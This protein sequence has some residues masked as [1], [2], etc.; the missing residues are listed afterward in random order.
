[1]KILIL[2][3]SSIGDIVLTTPVIRCL[4]N[5]INDLEI[6]YL[7]KSKFKIIL[8]NN[9]YIDKMYDFEK[10]VAEII[11]NL[12]AENYDY[13]I[14]LHNNLRSLSLKIK[15]KRKSSTFPKLNIKKWLLVN[16][17][18]NKMP[19]KHIVERYFDAVKF[20]GVKNDF[21]AC[22]YFIPNYDIVDVNKELGIEKY[23]T[24]AIGAQFATKRLPSAK[25]KELI[26]KIDEP[27]V[28]LGDSK[29][30][31]I[32]EEICNAFPNKKLIN[33]CSK[34]NLNQSASIV[35]Q[36]SVLITHDTG[37]MHIASAFNKHI[38][39]IWGNTIPALGMYPYYPKYS[40][41]FSIHQVENL[42]CR[43]CSKIGFQTCPKKHFSC[44]N[45]Q[46][47]EKISKDVLN[48]FQI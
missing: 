33:V 43:P 38:V 13:I 24:F 30:E 1:V 44:M 31:K 41:N 45:L 12:R 10:S 39:S 4:K 28:F 2:R 29:D 21:Q 9:I 46:D 14:D 40:E 11:P 6:H 32:A 7:T 35:K 25:I 22:D 18:L 23:I 34:F 20:L 42:S 5:Q 37:L 48:R 17:K 26:E 3:F 47:S 19:N 36:S 27:I 15:L 16:F 8:E